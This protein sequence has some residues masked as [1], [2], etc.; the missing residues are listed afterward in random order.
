MPTKLDRANW[1]HDKSVFMKWNSS[2]LKYGQSEKD[3]LGA[4][5]LQAA[6]PPYSVNNGPLNETSI[7]WRRNL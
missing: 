1:N 3:R 2:E 6:E 5:T 7:K 4:R